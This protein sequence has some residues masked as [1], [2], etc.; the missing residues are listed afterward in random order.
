MF[1]VKF[2]MIKINGQV[3]YWPISNEERDKMNPT[4]NCE[5]CGVDTQ[6]A[7]EESRKKVYCENLENI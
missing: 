1:K 2:G 4:H 7:W 5:T 3:V 6:R